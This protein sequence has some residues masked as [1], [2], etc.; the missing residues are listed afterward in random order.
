MIHNVKMIEIRFY[1]RADKI[2]LKRDVQWYNEK[3]CTLVFK[4]L[5]TCMR[6]KC[7]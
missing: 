7:T 3:H 5:S 1:Q 6:D 4:K 2:I